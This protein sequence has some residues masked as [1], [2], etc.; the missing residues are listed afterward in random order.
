MSDTFIT[1]VAI[2]LAA[3]LV[4]VVPL[5]T[6]AQRVDDVSQTDVETLTSNFIDEIRATGK[7]TADEYSKFLESLVATGNTYDVSIEFKILDENPGKKSTQ[8]TKD[9]IG[10][11]VYYSIYTTQIEEVLNDESQGNA[12]NLKQGDM[13]SVTVRNTNLTL[14]QQLKNFGYK[15]VGNDTYTISASKSG[16]IVGNGSTEIILSD[17]DS[18]VN[19]DKITYTLKENNA[20]GKI[21]KP[22]DWTNQDVYVELS[23]ESTYNLELFYYY[24]TK[25]GNTE[26]Y[27]NYYTKLDGNSLIFDNTTTIQAYWKSSA[28]E[29]YSNIETI[30]INIDRIKPTIGSISGSTQITNT[31]VIDVN[32]VVDTGGSGIYGYYY[33]WTD[34]NVAPSPPT[35]DLK[36]WTMKK[37]NNFTISTSAENNNK[38]CT[39]WVIDKAGNI[40]EPKSA[41]VKNVVPRI[42]KVEVKDAIIK[43]GE[44][45]EMDVNLIGG[46]SYKSFSGSAKDYSIA[47]LIAGTNKVFG[48]NAGRTQ[49]TYTITNYDGTTVTGTGTLTVVG[50]TYSPNGGNYV[51]SYN[52]GTVG[53]SIIKTTVKI[54]G[55]DTAKYAWSTSKT[56]APTSWSEYDTNNGGLVTKTSTSATTYY[57]WSKITDLSGNTT[58]F[59]SNSFVITSQKITITP[60]T[61]SWTNSDITCK[62]KYTGSNTTSTTMKVGYGAT[63]KDAIEASKTVTSS[64]TSITATDNGYVYAAATDAAGNIVATSLA[65]SNIDK[66]A[67]TINNSLN[68][69]LKNT[70]M[71]ANVTVTDYQS[72]VSKIVW[73]YK[74]TSSNNY[75]CI[76]DTYTSSANTENKSKT[77]SR[78]TQGTQYN[79]Y[80]VIYDAVGNSKQTS[81]V[82]VKTLIELIDANN[83][84]K[85][86]HKYA[87]ASYEGWIHTDFGLIREPIA[88]SADDI[89]LMDGTVY[90][91]SDVLNGEQ[92]LRG[93][94]VYYSGEEYGYTKK[95][96]YRFEAK[97]TGQNFD[98]RYLGNEVA[99]KYLGESYLVEQ[100]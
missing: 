22:G 66:I 6:T 21:I 59:V 36:N 47:T 77:I 75:E 56:I 12:Y 67:P 54:A 87:N 93:V 1:I 19:Q 7:L 52:N 58:T 97:S 44:T 86:A 53:K 100:Q 17:S 41:I 37:A 15:I 63:L 74:K 30:N 68:V 89:T 24:R 80:A 11:N 16:M 35:S 90:T 10:E 25:V 43:V 31:G 98:N 18:A 96:Y 49:I 33:A 50:I 2:I 26:D 62:I 76:T 65:I 79:I 34:P 20:N 40:S 29:K 48:N 42:T 83:T 81:V 64:T 82:T 88:M 39:V 8:T 14:G 55:A 5:M 45:A 94:I 60:S 46:T 61:T 84:T 69:T 72:G 71:I 32:N 4:F 73:Y 3:V 9:K 95:G 57:L 78:L 70:S 91:D 27:A 38:K 99:W 92:K 51:L 23:K 13:I 85:K 28:L